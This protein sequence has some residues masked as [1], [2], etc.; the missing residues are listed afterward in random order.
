MTLRTEETE[1][2]APCCVAR[3]GEDRAASEPQV[4]AAPRPER[5]AAAETA[6]RL[7]QL[8]GEES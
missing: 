2:G 3:T 6:R 7:I 8:P 4:F 1:P 5:D